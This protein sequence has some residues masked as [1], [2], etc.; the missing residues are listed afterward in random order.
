MTRVYQR[1]SLEYGL[2]LQHKMRNC[3]KSVWMFIQ[4]T[5]LLTCVMSL[6]SSATL[7]EVRC[8]TE[9]VASLKDYWRSKHSSD[10]FTGFVQSLLKSLQAFPSLSGLYENVLYVIRTY[11]D[12]MTTCEI[13]HSK[14]R[15]RLQHLP[16]QDAFF[17]I[18]ELKSRSIGRR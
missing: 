4:T 2:S 14:K 17:R 13:P 12:C 3:T 11:D 8:E 5:V 6:T 1:A 7:C 9:D 15:G 18:F 10:T 16:S